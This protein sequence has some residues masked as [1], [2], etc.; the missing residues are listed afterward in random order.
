MIKKILLGFTA[1]VWLMFAWN[2]TNQVLADNT[3]N[4][5]EYREIYLPEHGTE[6]YQD[7]HLHNIDNEWGIWGHNIDQILPD[8]PSQTIFARRDGVIHRDQYCFSSNELY[9][10]IEEYIET[11]YGSK[12]P[13]ARFAILPNDN[14]KV[15]LC[16]KCIEIGNTSGNATPAVVAMI[17][18]LAKRFPNHIFFT[19]DYAS[20]RSLPADTLPE[21]AGVLISAIEFPLSAVVTRKEHEFEQLLLDWSTKTDKVY[22]WDYINNF[23]DYFT[24]YP[25]FGPMQRRLKL[26]KNTGVQG[27]FLNGSGPDYSSLSRLK[28]HVLSAMLT[29]PDVDWKQVLRDKAKE[30]YPVTGDLISEFMIAQEDFVSSTGRELPLYDGIT[31]AL[32]TYLPD[33][34]FVEFHEAL[35]ERRDKT[36]GEERKEIDILCKVLGLTRLEM[37][38]KSGDIDGYQPHLDALM[39]LDSDDDIHVYS[40]T[41]WT[42]NSYARDFRRIVDEAA[43]SKGNKLKGIRLQ[44]LNALDPDYNDITIL[45]D[46]LLGMPSN[47]HNGILINSPEQ[48]WSIAVPPVPGLKKLRIWLVTNPAFRVGLPKRINLLSG[49]NVLGSVEPKLSG[50]KVGHTFI[51]FDVPSVGGTLTLT[52]AKDKEVRS[53]AIEEIEGF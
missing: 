51:D 4:A 21:N 49:G 36:S 47:Y 7:L 6:E 53:M 48:K 25:V 43:K 34:R 41:C 24:P 30:F 12:G 10:Y 32:E 18:R 16:S 29:D 42:L 27:I 35:L 14:S 13:T 37:M 8:R 5:F 31:K 2:C 33:N 52:F 28:T 15:C 19:S 40:E 9:N 17:R 45:T 1:V 46:G 26:Y 23:D 3:V 20:T 22:V 39:S 11:N 38:R 44:A 50:E